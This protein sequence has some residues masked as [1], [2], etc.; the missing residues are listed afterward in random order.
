LEKIKERCGDEIAL[1]LGQGKFNYER[2]LIVLDSL[3]NHSL[4]NDQKQNYYINQKANKLYKQLCQKDIVSK[5]KTCPKFEIY[6]RCRIL[7]KISNTDWIYISMPAVMYS[8]YIRRWQKQSNSYTFN[9][10]RPLAVPS[11][12]VKNEVVIYQE[13]KDL[14]EPSKNENNNKIIEYEQH[15]DNFV[16]QEESALLEAIYPK[17][18]M[19]TKRKLE[20]LTNIFEECTKKNWDISDLALYNQAQVFSFT[21]SGMAPKIYSKYDILWKNKI[22]DYLQKCR[23][24]IKEKEER[25]TTY[26]N[27]GDEDDSDTEPEKRLTMIEQMRRRIAGSQDRIKQRQYEH[28][29]NQPNHRAE[30]EKEYEY[31]HNREMDAL[32]R[33]NLL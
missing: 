22:E 32:N 30:W 10:Q 11:E 1:I 7:N 21:F 20:D 15:L 5:G 8:A 23:Q 9:S 2:D 6:A 29:N 14:I 4:S 19:E 27:A 13:S 33:N 18:Y 17:N 24:D 31:A 16:T 26:Y 25:K 12:T 3:Y 28:Y